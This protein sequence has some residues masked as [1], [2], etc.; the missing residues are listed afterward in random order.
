MALRMSGAISTR[1]TVTPC[2]RGSR[3]CV[4]MAMLTTSRTASAAF[5]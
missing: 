5:S 4:R 2:T 1:V 3:T